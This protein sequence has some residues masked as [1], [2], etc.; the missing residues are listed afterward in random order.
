MN[1]YANTIPNIAI[2]NIDLYCDGNYPRGISILYS[3]DGQKSIQLN[4]VENVF[5]SEMLR[6]ESIN[7]RHDE[8]VT[9]IDM[10]KH[11]N[12]L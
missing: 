9:Q 5:E 11:E 3:I 7:L 4:Y 1:Y 12:T 2:V 10:W 6:K 8:A